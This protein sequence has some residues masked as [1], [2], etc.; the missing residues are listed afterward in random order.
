MFLGLI[1]RFG[2]LLFVSFYINT[3]KILASSLKIW[4]LSR[5]VNSKKEV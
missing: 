3:A 2:V 5:G 1:E 4:L